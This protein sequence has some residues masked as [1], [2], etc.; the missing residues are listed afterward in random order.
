MNEETNVENQ[1]LEELILQ[2]LEQ[3]RGGVKIYTQALACAQSD[4]LR[5]KWQRYLEQTRQHVAA[6]EKVCSDVGIDPERETVGR[7]AI[8]HI[9]KALVEAMQMGI[10][11]GPAAAEIL[12]CECIVLAETKDHF[13]WELLGA[14][15]EH[16][17]TPEAKVLRGPYQEIEDQEDEHVYHTKGWCRE[18]WARSLGMNAMFPPPEELGRVKTA[19]GA[20]NAQQTAEK[21]R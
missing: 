2:S 10:Q 7:K 21:S 17:E 18:L 4:E 12:A 6:L 5:T 3:E 15:S 8:A 9:G 19:V 1:Q 11:A 20:A 14:C 13:D 16:L